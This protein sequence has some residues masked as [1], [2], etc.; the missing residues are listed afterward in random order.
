MNTGIIRSFRT[1][2]SRHGGIFRKRHQQSGRRCVQCSCDHVQ[3]VNS[4][5]MLAIQHFCESRLRPSTEPSKLRLR[6]SAGLH[7]AADVRHHQFLGIHL[8]HSPII[9]NIQTKA[10]CGAGCSINTGSRQRS[11][12][13]PARPACLQQSPTQLIVGPCLSSGRRQART[14]DLYRVRIA[15]CQRTP[16]LESRKT[17]CPVRLFAVAR[18]AVTT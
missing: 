17:K 14:G 18:G 16:H 4:R 11:R 12:L 8:L 13:S 15:L 6:E 1:T 3:G 2:S 10:R 9:R 5:P 7:F